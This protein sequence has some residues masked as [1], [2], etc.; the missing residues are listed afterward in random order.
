MPLFFTFFFLSDDTLQDITSHN[1]F[2]H[3]MK[4][5]FMSGAAVVSHIFVMRLGQVRF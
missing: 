5:A 4:Q 1:F 2:F 3:I